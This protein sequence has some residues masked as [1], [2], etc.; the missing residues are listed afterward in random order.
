MD[1]GHKS[2]GFHG[3]AQ[4]T[5]TSQT[6]RLRLEL[7]YVLCVGVRVLLPSGLIM[8]IISVKRQSFSMRTTDLLEKV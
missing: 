7:D 2:D 8:L 6:A 1:R 5:M 3:T 4:S